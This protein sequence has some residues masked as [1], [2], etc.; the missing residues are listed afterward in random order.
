VNFHADA[1]VS[2]KGFAPGRPDDLFGVA[3]GY[4]RISNGARSLDYDNMAFNN[5]L[6]P[7]RSGEALVEATYIASVAPGWTLQ[8][9]LQY[10]R[11][12]GGNI[13]DP[14]DATGIRTLRDAF[15]IGLRTLI[16]Y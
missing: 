1:G 3:L 8:P 11:R 15:V 7:I 9:D 5:P 12:P 16:R 4:A 6:A 13:P 10:I 2:F 14:R